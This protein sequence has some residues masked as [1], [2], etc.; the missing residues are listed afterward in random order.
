MSHLIGSDVMSMLPI[1]PLDKSV[2]LKGKPDSQGNPTTPLRRYGYSTP[3]KKEDSKSKQMPV[4]APR[5][6][7]ET[8]STAFSINEQPYNKTGTQSRQYAKDFTVSD[9]VQT[10]LK[11]RSRGGGLALDGE[12]LRSSAKGDLKKSKSNSSSSS[13]SSSS[14]NSSSNGLKGKSVKDAILSKFGGK[15]NKSK[16]NTPEKET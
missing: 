10:M 9:D 8:D 1:E 6:S 12:P 2:S 13:S 16:S 11:G 3:P 7:F 5:Q 15:G 4:T 14:S